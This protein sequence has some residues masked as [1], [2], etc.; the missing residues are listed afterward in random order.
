MTKTRL[1]LLV[2][3]L[4][5]LPAKANDLGG[6]FNDHLL[7]QLSCQTNPDATASLLYLIKR[8]A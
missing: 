7:I 4:F 1:M 3:L 6:T 5:P 8:G 2:L